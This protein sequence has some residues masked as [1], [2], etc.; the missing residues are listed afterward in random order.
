AT[1]KEPVLR[2]VFQSSSS[3]FPHSFQ[4]FTVYRSLGLL[5]LRKSTYFLY[6]QPS[7][8][9]ISLFC[10]YKEKMNRPAP[11]ADAGV[12]RYAASQLLHMS[13]QRMQPN[14]QISEFPGQTQCPSQA[15]GR[16]QWD[17]TPQ[18]ELNP[19]SPPSYSQGKYL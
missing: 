17:T 12:N 16:Q 15:D 2:T 3:F 8:Q 11:Y 19:M 10:D 18:I 13:A 7:L 1:K 14:A 6:R 9:V 4:N 5:H